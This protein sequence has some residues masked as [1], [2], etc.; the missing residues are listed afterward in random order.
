ML[1]LQTVTVFILQPALYWDF[2]WHNY[3]SK[4]D[5]NLVRMNDLFTKEQINGSCAI[6]WGITR[7]KE[8]Q[9]IFWNGVKRGITK[10]NH[11]NW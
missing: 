9:V 8:A 11:M 6:H 3:F 10:Q 5:I 7:D 2:N 1:Q 4:D